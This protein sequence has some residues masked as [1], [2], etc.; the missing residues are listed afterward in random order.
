[1]NEPISFQSLVR[2]FDG[3]AGF[4][5]RFHVVGAEHDEQ[6]IRGGVRGERVRGL[7]DLVGELRGIAGVE[8]RAI[9]VRVRA[10]RA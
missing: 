8:G 3:F 2:G 4:R 5:G 6:I 1:M 7:L 9:A 10:G